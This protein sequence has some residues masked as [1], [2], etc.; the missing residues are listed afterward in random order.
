MV[1]HG[2]VAVKA[3][4][5]AERK[6]KPGISHRF[7]FDPVNDSRAVLL[8]QTLQRSRRYIGKRLL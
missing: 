8:E 6:L 5:T 3:P 7:V 1:K 2:I 4:D